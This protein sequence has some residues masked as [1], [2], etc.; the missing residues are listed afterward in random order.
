MRSVRI[1]VLAYGKVTKL[2]LPDTKKEN[3]VRGNM[4]IY[5]ITLLSFY[6]TLINAQNRIIVTDKD[7]RALP[8]AHIHSTDFKNGYIADDNGLFVLNTE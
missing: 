4:K 7:N 2:V 6:M 5:F 8:Y 1:V 3:I